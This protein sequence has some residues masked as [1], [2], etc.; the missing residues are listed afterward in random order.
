M[1]FDIITIFPESFYWLKNFS[2]IGKAIEENKIKIN[3]I[4]LRK[5]SKNK[6]KKVDDDIYGHGAGMVMTPQPLFDAIRDLK[7]ENSKVVLLSPQGQLL[8]QEKSI[9]F[10]K[11]EHL[12]LICGHYEGIDQRVID[13]FV[14]IE[15]SIGD[16]VL[17][18]GEIPAMVLID[19]VARFVPSVVGNANSLTEDSL[20]QGLLKHPVYTRPRTYEGMEVPEI[21]L[22]GDHKKIKE[23]EAKESL[24]A[25]KEKR[26]DL[27]KSDNQV[28]WSIKNMLYY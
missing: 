8:N 19:A 14:D 25:T 10:S 12:I 17:T 9:K 13:K 27:L 11:E 23:W 4:D 22:S 7:K 28:W 2:L 20:Y 24:R 18:G 6:H 15:I 26:P 16:Y 5:Y 1:I 3:P 21:L